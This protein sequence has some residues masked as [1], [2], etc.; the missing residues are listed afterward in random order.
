MKFENRN[1]G[2]FDLLSVQMLADEVFDAGRLR[3]ET[4]RMVE[5]GSRRLVIDLGTVDYLY[6]DSINA[7]V[8]LNRRMLESSGRMGILVPSPKVYDILVRAGLENIMRLYRS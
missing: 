7:L 8:A 4:L 6:S 3:Q 5:R 2:V 1:I